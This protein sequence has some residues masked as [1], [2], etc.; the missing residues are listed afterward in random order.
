[1]LVELPGGGGTV[2]A[3]GHLQSAAVKIEVWHIDYDQEENEILYHLQLRELWAFFEESLG[4]MF[5]Q[6]RLCP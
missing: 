3:G 4:I 2:G 5:R 6:R 1:M